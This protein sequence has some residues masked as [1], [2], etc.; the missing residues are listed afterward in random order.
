MRARCNYS[1][2]PTGFCFH[3]GG[4]LS[5]S[6]LYYCCAFCRREYLRTHKAPSKENPRNEPLITVAMVQ[7]DERA[8]KRRELKAL[9]FDP[10]DLKPVSRAPQDAPKCKQPGCSRRLSWPGELKAGE[11]LPHLQE[12]L[13][14]ERKEA[15]LITS[16]RVRA[17]SRRSSARVRS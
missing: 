2:A 9:G 10:E 13:H 16:E 12:R 8:E 6:Q 11:C 1:V 4:P 7:A 14:K 3:C 5:E 15:V 17:S